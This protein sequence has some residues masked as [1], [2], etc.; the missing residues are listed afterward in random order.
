M[1]RP[2]LFHDGTVIRRKFHHGTATDHREN[3]V[4]RNRGF[5]SRLFRIPLIK[6]YV[7][8]DALHMRD[9]QGMLSCLEVFQGK[10]GTGVIRSDLLCY[11]KE[12]STSFTS[13]LR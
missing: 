4:W 11:Y 3:S 1:F 2:L 10:I 8:T 12:Y 7:F 6:Q 13:H 5:F 9:I